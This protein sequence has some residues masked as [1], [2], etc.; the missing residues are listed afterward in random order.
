MPGFPIAVSEGHDATN[1][2]APGDSTRSKVDLRVGGID[3]P[4]SEPRPLTAEVVGIGE[5]KFTHNGHGGHNLPVNMGRAAVILCAATTIVL[6]ERKGLGSSPRIYREV[7]LEPRRY[8]LVVA[9]SPE[10]FRHDYEAIA[11]GFLYCGAP[12]VASENL[13]EL[14]FKNVDRP[15]YPLDNFENREDAG[16]PWRIEI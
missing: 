11:A 9:K 12:G 6:T 2:G 1:S 14:G 15:L 13:C 5:I 3:D 16:W 7:A 10:G 8:K 4:Y